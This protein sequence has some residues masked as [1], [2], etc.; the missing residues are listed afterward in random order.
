MAN[1]PNGS[2]VTTTIKIGGKNRLCRVKA[3]T[4]EALGLTPATK[5]VLGKRGR[6]KRGAKGTKSY[7]LYFRAPTEVGGATVKTVDLPVPGEVKV[8]D[9]YNWGVKQGILAGMRTPWGISYFWSDRTDEGGPGLVGQVSGVAQTIVDAS[10]FVRNRITDTDTVGSR[11]GDVVDA[12]QAAREG[13]FL[14]AG[15]E[16]VDAI[17]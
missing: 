12:F 13:R 5:L 2:R 3:G 4:V 14:E 1:L 16:V 11:L 17:F 7:T 10:N 9:M 6:I 8:T 15:A